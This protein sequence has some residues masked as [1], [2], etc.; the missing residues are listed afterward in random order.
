MGSFTNS[1][2]V[3]LVV[4]FRSLFAS[5]MRRAAL[6]S[7]AL[8]IVLVVGTYAYLKSLPPTS[9]PRAYVK[10]SFAEFYLE[11]DKSEYQFGENMTIT[12]YVNNTSNKTIEILKGSM[13]D[14]PHELEEYFSTEAYGVSSPTVDLNLFL[15]FGFVIEYIN[16]TVFE[17]HLQGWIQTAYRLSIESGGYLKQTT[18]AFGR[19]PSSTYR[20]KAE[21]AN[22]EHE[23]VW[24]GLETPTLVFT[25]R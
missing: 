19:L 15:H 5:R 25:V 24:Y 14:I 20:I 23:S 7:T 10:T 4:S 6:V 17:N 3:S 8:I 11:L 2:L 21:F 1:V 22:V 18:S 16:G 9:G 13:D 12:F